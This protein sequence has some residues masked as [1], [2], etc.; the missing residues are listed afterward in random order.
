[1]K[2][3][4]KYFLPYMLDYKREFIFAILGMIAV[5]VGTTL[6]AHLLK[7]VLDDIFINKDQEMLKL[8]PFAIVGVFMLKSTG[9]FV[10]TYYTVYIGDDIVRKLR[11]RLALHLMYQDID[12]LNKMRSG[13]LLSR[14]TN[15]INRIQSVVSSMI[16]TLMVKAMLIVTLTAYVI[17]QSPKLAF[18]FLVIMPLALLPLQ[19]LARKMKKYSKRSQESNSDL[20]SRLTEIFNNIEVIKSSSSQEYEYERFSKENMNFFQ[21]AIKQM[22]VNALVGP[23]LEVFG[24]VAIAV[25]IYVGAL[26]VIHDEITVGTFF[27][28][29]TALFM[30]YDPIKV[31]S[32]IHN[33][34]QDAVAATERMSELFESAPTIVSGNKE[35]QYVEKVIF[36]NVSLDYG[37]K[38]AL[39]GISLE[40]RKGKVYALVGDSGAGKSSFVNLLVRFYEPTL[41]ELKINDLNIAEYTL[42]SLHRKIAYVTQRIYI[43]QDTVLANVAY[44]SE[45]D[46]EQVIAALKKAQAWEFVKEMDEG[47]YTSLDEFGVNLSG[48]QRQRIAL[49]RAL[50]KSP[51]ILILDEATSALD[52]K[53]EKAIQKALEGIKNEM[54]TF[55]VAHRL[56]TVENADT[57]LLFEEGRI[58]DRGSY[59][60]LLSRSEAFRRLANKGEE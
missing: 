56:S 55:I 25:A 45:A 38:K 28:F 37:G 48:G 54:V 11:D 35:L 20:T 57:I 6:S 30:L 36:E 5:A 41:G 53:S 23:S 12:Y 16:P 14:V 46:E 34:I 13:E 15:D 8:I 24:S 40:A 52:N 4:I 32:N 51:E 50:Y 22:R 7:P 44:G 27:A 17:Y 2:Q 33:R 21:L 18:Y 1:M 58:I 60:E 29:V 31:L 43:F 9:R 39:E 3:L 19:I 47:I 49:A 26:Q 10:Q 42:D 59:S